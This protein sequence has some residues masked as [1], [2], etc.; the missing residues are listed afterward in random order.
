MTI[1]GLLFSAEDLGVSVVVT[2]MWPQWSHSPHDQWLWHV[3]NKTDFSLPCEQAK[4]IWMISPF[5]KHVLTTVC[6]GVRCVGSSTSLACGFWDY[7]LEAPEN[8]TCPPSCRHLSSSCFPS[9]SKW[10]Q[11]EKGQIMPLVDWSVTEPWGNSFTV[12]ACR[13][14]T[15][16]HIFLC[17]VLWDLGRQMLWES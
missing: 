8:R 4:L 10:F 13:S 1:W 11:K 2:L 9:V 5:A 7:M 16:M 14:L 15:M 6:Q 3:I 12:S 17:S